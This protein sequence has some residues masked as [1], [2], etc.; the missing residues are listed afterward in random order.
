MFYLKKFLVPTVSLVLLVGFI[1]IFSRVSDNTQNGEDYAFLT[2]GGAHLIFNQATVLEITADNTFIVEITP[3]PWIPLEYQ[4]PNPGDI[5][6]MYVGDIVEVLL[7]GHDSYIVTHALYEGANV[8][9]ER[10]NRFDFELDFQYTP[11]RASIEGVALNG[12]NYEEYTMFSRG[13]FPVWENDREVIQWR[14]VVSG[15]D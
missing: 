11:P 14:W 4:Q 6:N 13:N 5:H 9:L 8:R 3:L 10:L 12:D 15:G 1:F 7:E 2:V